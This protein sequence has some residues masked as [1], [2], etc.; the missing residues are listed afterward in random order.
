MRPLRLLIITLLLAA[1]GSAVLSAQ[2]DAPLVV[3]IEEPRELGMAS[4]T[5]PGPDGISKLAALFNR[6]G[7]VTQWIRLREEADVPQEADV[8]VLVNPRRE[9]SAENLA[10]VWEQV[11]AGAA[12][13]VAID[14]S[15]FSGARTERSTGGLSTLTTL[16]QGVTLLDGTLIEPWFTNDSLT[17]VNTMLSLALPDPVPHPVTDLLRR[18]DL[19]VVLWG[20]RPLRAEP[21]GINSFAHALLYTEPAFAEVDVA[22]YPTTREPNPPPFEL[23]IGVDPQGRLH[24]AAIGEN[25]VSGTRI[26][27]LG[28]AEMLQ[29]GF[30]LAGDP[31]DPQ[32]LA[33]TILTQ[34]LVGWLLGLP[35]EEWLPP[36]GDYVYIALDGDYTD[37]PEGYISAADPL[38]DTSIAAQDI[39]EIRSVRNNA[40]VYMSIITQM[41]VSALAEVTIEIDQNA[42]GTGDLILQSNDGRILSFDADGSEIGV[43]DD[44]GYGIGTGID[45]RLPLRVTG[46]NPRIVDV[47]VDTTRE[48][49]FPQPPDCYGAAL[50]V[51]SIFAEDPAPNRSTSLPLA[52]LRP[53]NTRINLRET[54][55]TEARILNT[56]PAGT[57]FAV[58]GRTPGGNWV[59][60]QNAAW[61]GWLNVATLYL[62][63]DPASLPIVNF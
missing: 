52:L 58:T 8:I 9:L 19:P 16:E 36:P 41:P 53:S 44:A 33:N 63:V 37:L 46:Q 7:A 42:D 18:Y 43:V 62:E 32:Y 17:D 4:I 57:I 45:L 35:P 21:F 14:P 25:T 11:G 60:V 48:L 55:S 30:G 22:V 39:T 56:F 34:N 23:N 1:L 20:A 28:D 31:S 24:V 5:D 26:A 3:F 29:N 6:Y 47:C 61:E 38:G 40:Y 59:R 51:G 2:V 54:P 13:L 10:R 27:V 12:L 49:A 15:G 50:P